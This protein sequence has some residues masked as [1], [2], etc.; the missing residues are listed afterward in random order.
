MINST[1]IERLIV[2]EKRAVAFHWRC[3]IVIVGTAATILLLNWSV[4]WI[5][6]VGG[7][8]GN[9]FITLLAYFP[10][11]QISKRK[12]HIAALNLLK[13]SL[14]KTGRRSSDSVKFESAVMARIQ[15]MLEG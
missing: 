9:L 6:N 12:D 11:A 4:G 14:A 5:S 13:D 10:L 2:Y 15:H 7:A 8:L 3:F 1:T